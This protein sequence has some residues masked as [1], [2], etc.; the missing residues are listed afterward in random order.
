MDA[1]VT[2]GT[3][4]VGANL[5]RE[6]LADGR[7]VRVLARK[8]G[9]R[10]RARG[11]RRR[12]RGGRSPRRRARSARRSPARGASITSP[13][14]TGS[15]R[16]DPRELYRA[17]VDGTRHILDG[18]GGGGGRAHRLHLDRGRPRHSQGRH[19]GRRDDA[20]G[21]R[22]HG[23]AVQGLQV[24]RR[25]RRR[26]AGR[27]RGARSSS[28]I[29]RRPSARGTSSPR[30]PGR[31]S[32]TSSAA[33][34]SARSTPDSTSSTCATS[35]AAT[36]WPPSVAGWARATS[37]AIENLSLIEIFRALARPHRAARRR[38]SA[39]PTRVAWI[40]GALHGGRRR[41]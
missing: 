19:A 34:W 16:A 35:P 28:S 37:W 27:A 3:G 12:D 6:L 17:N 39:C 38:A 30:P 41:A 33:R 18:G 8:G 20:R 21:A 24:P 2:G 26:R 11:L 7:T 31:W 15:G 29:P 1:L 22:G 14:T 13:P 4:F 25:A 40:G 23:G 10:T 36:S 9:D 5:V 32:W